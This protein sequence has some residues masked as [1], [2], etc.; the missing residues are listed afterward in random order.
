MTVVFRLAKCIKQYTGN[1]NLHEKY[2]ITKEY[3]DNF[4]TQL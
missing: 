3:S 2:Y 4:N 1:Y